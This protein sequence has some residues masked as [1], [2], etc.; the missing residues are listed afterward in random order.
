MR[1]WLNA[2]YGPG[3]LVATPATSIGDGFDNSIHCVR[4]TGPSLPEEW[5]QPLIARVQ[6][7]EDRVS[8]AQREALI[9]GWCADQGYP[10]PRVRAVA[11]PHDGFGLPVQLIERPPGSTMFAVIV[12]APWRSPALNDRLAS[13]HA[14]LHALP[15]D[16]WPQPGPTESLADRRLAVVRMVVEE[17]DH[18]ELGRATRQVEYLRSRFEDAPAVVCHGDFHPLNV[19]VDGHRAAVIDWTGRRPR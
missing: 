15:T 2:Q 5:Q 9:Q 10:A 19:L 11:A 6:P 1:E 8:T 4:F 14:Q 18:A 7:S 17:L 13:L 12:G 3:V 16:T